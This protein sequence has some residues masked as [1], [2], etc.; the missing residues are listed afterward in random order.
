MIRL[1]LTIETLHGTV[2]T[3][4]SPICTSWRCDA[5]S[6][7]GRVL[8]VAIAIGEACVVYM[9]ARAFAIKLVAWGMI[10]PDVTVWEVAWS[11]SS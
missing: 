8:L 11:G 5:V 7:E 2:L 1:I 6:V 10:V 3:L 9:T 4:P